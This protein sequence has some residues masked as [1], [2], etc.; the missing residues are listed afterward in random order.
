MIRVAR[1]EAARLAVAVLVLAATIGAN[2]GSQDPLAAEIERWSAFARDSRETHPMW[3]PV[4]Q[5]TEPVLARARTALAAGR[6]F[7]ALQ[8]LGVA[9]INLAAFLYL[10]GL[11]AS[12]RNDL[13]RLES[14]WGRDGRALKA[15]LAKTPPSA[16]ADV[17]PAA[18]RA[19]AEAALP[20]VRAFY[21]A[22]LDYGHSTDAEAGLFY[23]G[24]ARSQRE[25]ASF[26][27]R[28]STPSPLRAPGLRSLAPELDGLEGELLA[29]YRPP[30]AIERHGDFIAAS[31]VLKEAREL[32]AAEL[33]YGALLRY[34]LAAQRSAQLRPDPPAF[35]PAAIAARMR[36]LDR[37]LSAKGID[38]S[39]GRLFLESAEAEAARVA[40]NSPSPVA[41][42]IVSD[43]IPR[44]FAALE[45]RRAEPPKPAPLVAVT[46]VRWPYT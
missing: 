1:L 8:Q 30:A 15:D 37:L 7:L 29:R 18:I 12:E 20:Q 46:L 23:L 2:A 26:C 44:Y 28:L 32:D 22:S 3:A 31:S 45:P 19:V 41:A 6:R 43:V 5:A 10:A 13:S 42:A 39:I 24:A 33:R 21:D 27:R 25:F 16:F 9:R 34:L 17:Q 4:K 40:P 35:E 11:P 38:H 36:E 14:E